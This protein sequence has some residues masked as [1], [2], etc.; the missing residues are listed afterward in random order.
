VIDLNARLHTSAYKIPETIREQV[1]LRDRLTC[2]FPWCTRPARSAD[3]DHIT[4]YDEGGQ[5]A[6]DNL[7]P[8][9]RHHHRLKTHGG[10][11]YT[12]LEPGR[13]L[14]RSPLGYSYLRD[15]DRTEDL[16]APPVERP[17]STG[18]APDR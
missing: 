10:W 6:S 1:I 7:A 3:I 11:T 15:R 8:L 16:T 14:W 4:P 5:T 17:T 18:H 2:I 9:C 12:S 13:Y